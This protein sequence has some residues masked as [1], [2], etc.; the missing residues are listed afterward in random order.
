MIS[1][2]WYNIGFDNVYDLLKSYF[3]KKTFHSSIKIYWTNIAGLKHTKKYNYWNNKSIC[4]VQILFSL[5]C[6]SNP[7]LIWFM[8][9]FCI[10][11]NRCELLLSLLREIFMFLFV[12]SYVPSEIQL[13]LKL[14]CK[15]FGISIVLWDLT[16]YITW[17]LDSS[18]M[19]NYEWVILSLS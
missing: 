2:V 6:S 15:I 11:N 3:I 1:H 13:N 8:N 9:K 5:T 14:A 10:I 16:F 19:G 7:V 17:C 18:F 12:F 4:I